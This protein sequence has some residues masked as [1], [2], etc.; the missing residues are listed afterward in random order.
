MNIEKLSDILQ[1]QPKFR[2]KQVEKALYSDFITNWQDLSVLPKDLREK[3]NNECP[4]DI[5]AK[6]FDG[7]NRGKKALITLEDGQEIETVLIRQK[8][9]DTLR[10]TVCLSTQIGC[11]LACV[12]CATGKMGFTRNLESSEI[13]EQVIF[14]ARYLKERDEKID[15]IVYMGMGEPFLNYSQF[16]KSVKFL[17]DVETFNIGARRLSVSTAGITE[18]IKKLAGEKIQ[19]NLAI[20]LHAADDDLRRDLM[21]VAKKYRIHEILKEVDRYILKTNR[22]VMFEYLMIKEVNDSDKDAEKLVK[23]MK[24]PLYMVNLIPYNSTGRFQP[25]SE[26][27]IDKFKEILENEGV[28]V[29]VRK[30]YG[31]EIGAACGQLKGSSKKK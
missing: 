7:Q 20:S 14:W 24:K 30:S 16:I 17:N 28:A 3:L 9:D 12:F 10:Y 27:R 15:N 29:T 31:A 18:G 2:F 22:R 25:S 6:I 26:K 13:I 21:P 19:V 23:L 1:D 5:E 4:L 8:H 11:P